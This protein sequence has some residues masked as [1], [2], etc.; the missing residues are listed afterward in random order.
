MS[1]KG[2]DGGAAAAAAAAALAFSPATTPLQVP[3]KLTMEACEILQILPH[4]PLP[5]IQKVVTKFG[6]D[7]DR[8]EKSV[9]F[10]LNEDMASSPEWRRKIA[11]KR[12]SPEQ[13]KNWIA[14]D[15]LEECE[16]ASK[17]KRATN[18][19]LY[20]EEGNIE[21]EKQLRC[22]EDF[23]EAEN[24]DSM[25]ECPVCCEEKL[26]IKH[27]KPCVDGHLFCESCVQKY[28][29]EVIGQG[30]VDFLCLDPSCNA[31]FSYSILQQILRPSALSRVLR[32][33]Q[34]EEIQAANI[35]NLEC[36]AFCD[37]ATIMEDPK[38]KIFRCLN[39]ECMKE[40]CRLCKR[41][42]HIPRRCEEIQQEEGAERARVYFE[43]ELSEAV[44]RT[45][46]K[47]GTRFMKEEGCNKMTCSCGAKM[48]YLCKKP[49]EDYSHFADNDPSKCP[50]WTDSMSLHA[51]EVHVKAAEVKKKLQ[52]ENPNL[53]LKNDPRKESPEMPEGR[54][55]HEE[56]HLQ[57]LHNWVQQFCQMPQENMEQGPRPGHQTQQ[58]RQQ[59]PGG[60]PP[61]QVR[62]QQPPGGHPPQQL[63]QLPHG[64]HP[65]QQVRQQPLR[66]HQ[67]QQARL[68]APGGHAAL[69]ARKQPPGGHAPLQAR[70]LPPGGHLVKQMQCRPPGGHQSQ[71]MR[72][73]APV[74][75]PAQKPRQ[76]PPGSHQAQQARHPVLNQPRWRY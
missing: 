4:I 16:N 52:D 30:R 11:E 45:C 40:S 29:E 58:A 7:A 59:P 44:I 55:Q 21:R 51:K 33:K 35:Q 56:A 42:S 18:E 3:H 28:A 39:P 76:Q 22:E 41:P 74:G 61:Q 73:P 43:N 15:S 67:P 64:G 63:R 25:L 47:C 57:A 66:G 2:G 68:Q 20:F 8:I 13:Q 10:L 65:L 12:H 37:F 32:R 54:A 14:R 36:C 24:A 75:H 31:T 26:I 50:L 53:E 1:C 71:Q 69:Q 46:S 19:D 60:H 34:A 17:V 9:N 23:K 6:H 5:T 38:E 27:M 49:V 72:Q 48:C 70:Q 62:R